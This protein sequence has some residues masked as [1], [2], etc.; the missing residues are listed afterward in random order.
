MLAHTVLELVQACKIYYHVSHS[1]NFFLSLSQHSASYTCQVSG[2]GLKS[3]TLNHPTHI[4]VE[5]TDPN[6]RPNSLPQ[7]VTAQLEVTGRQP[8]STPTKPRWRWSK[9]EKRIS[10]AMISPSRYEVSYTPVSRGQHKLFVQVN[11]REIKGSPFTVTVYPDPRHLG[12]PVRTVTGLDFPHGV[13]IN[14]H[15]E[16]IISERGAHRVSILD[17]MG[18]KI[19]SFGSLGQSPDQIRHPRGIATDDSN[20]IYVSSQDKVQKFTASGEFIKC[21]HQVGEKLLDNPHG[22]TLFENRVYICDANNHCIR[23]FDL[24]LN[25]VQSIGSYGKGSGE[26]MTPYDVKFDPAGNMYVVDY[27]K[28]NVQVMDTSGQFIRAFGQTGKGK[29]SGPSG[30]YLADKYVYVSDNNNDR[31]VV[32]ETS[33]QFVTMFGK[34][35]HNEGEFDGPYYIT[36]CVDGFIH[37]CD[38]ANNR[39]QIF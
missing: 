19:R 25:Y 2:S 9:D 30:L 24:D 39:V 23:V 36:A 15:Q 16:M 31:I 7:N 37:I 21:I 14:T 34:Y 6:G 33:G 26:L 27:G 32:Y 22:V 17:M 10:V 18:E 20:S 29:L 5:L 38:L 12:L 28:K 3:A 11:G 4:I 13:V 8:H 1:D 35:G